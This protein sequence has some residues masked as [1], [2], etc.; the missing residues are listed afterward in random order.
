MHICLDSC[1][2]PVGSKDV[3]RCDKMPQPLSTRQHETV[4]IA[5]LP[6]MLSS[7]KAKL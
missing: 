4:A 5:T 7:L 1:F 6:F 3:C 2:A